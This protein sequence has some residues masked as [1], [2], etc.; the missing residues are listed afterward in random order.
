MIKKCALISWLLFSTT[1]WYNFLFRL[2]SNGLLQDEI[3]FA[4]FA[5][6]MILYIKEKGLNLLGHMYNLLK[7][8]KPALYNY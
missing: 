2:V 4:H 6:W 3:D 8:I 5:I 7:N 1:N